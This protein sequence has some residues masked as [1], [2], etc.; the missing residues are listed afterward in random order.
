MPIKTVS[1]FQLKN[2]AKR[3]QA[4]VHGVSVGPFVAPHG[5]KVEFRLARPINV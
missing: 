4:A 1:G 5:T 2:K 3:G